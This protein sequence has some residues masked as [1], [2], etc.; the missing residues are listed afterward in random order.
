M[1]ERQNITTPTREH[2]LMNS[3]IRK[4]GS[5]RQNQSSFLVLSAATLPLRTCA[6]DA[7]GKDVAPLGVGGKCAYVALPGGGGTA[8]L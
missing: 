8:G 4:D 6:P 2:H 3:Q 5:P 7:G 1:Y